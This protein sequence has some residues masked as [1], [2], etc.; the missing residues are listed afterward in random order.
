MMNVVGD[1]LLW[2]P[3]I[4]GLSHSGLP[5]IS[6]VLLPNCTPYYCTCMLQIITAPLRNL[7]ILSRHT[8]GSRK[9]DKYMGAYKEVHTLR[10]SLLYGSQLIAL[11]MH[12]T[13]PCLLCAVYNMFPVF[14]FCRKINHYF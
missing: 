11:V 14:I 12:T 1:T 4:S 6:P 8:F 13:I 5:H 10:E 3:P 2:M 9:A 7:S